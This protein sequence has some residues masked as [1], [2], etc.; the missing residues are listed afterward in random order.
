MDRDATEKRI[1]AEEQ[2]D[3]FFQ[4]LATKYGL[5]PEDLHQ[6]LDD[7][8]W[9]RQY[10]VGVVRIQWAVA[11]GVMAVAVS[12]LV[13]ALWDGIKHAIKGN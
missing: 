13:S 1:Q 2:L 3:V 12:G 10:R 5:K 4:L 8:R 11:L 7:M 9:V 6:I